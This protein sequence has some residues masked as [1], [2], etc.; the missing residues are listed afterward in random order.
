MPR[1]VAQDYARNIL[2]VNSASSLFARDALPAGEGLTSARKAAQSAIARQVGCQPEE[3]AIA[4][5]GSDALQMLITN[6]RDLKPG[7]A[8]VHCDLDYDTTIGA[9]KWLEAHRDVRL[10]RFAMPEPAS[11][12]NVLAAY[13]DVLKRTPDAKLLLV[14]HISHRTGLVTPVREIVAMARARGVDTIVDAAHSVALLDFQLDDLG[15]DFVGWSVHKWTSAPLGTGAMYIRKGRLNDIEPAFENDF[16]D[17]DD[18]NAR[19]P[20]GTM[21]FGALLTIP[22]AVE[23]HF[24]V[25]AAVKE[26]HMRG[27]RDRWVD[28][29]R[30]VPGVSMTVPDDPARYCAITSFRIAGMN[31]P[32]RARTLQRVLLEKHR[33]QTVSRTGI[34]GGP[35]IRVTPGFFTTPEDMDAL[36]KAIRAEHAMFA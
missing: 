18:I 28:A 36:V 11:K 25:G 33:V 32:D 29:V 14:T 34:A 10:V 3:I 7:Q 1:V 24:A 27:L 17:P 12:A 8:V 30:D 15:A 23:F 4:R 31:T 6:Y 9:M 13:E 16:F 26:Q 35:A 22:K 21:D 2:A 20:D 5:S 19:I